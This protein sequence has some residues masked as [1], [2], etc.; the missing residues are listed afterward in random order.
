MHARQ[1]GS[2]GFFSEREEEERESE[3]KVLFLAGAY[4]HLSFQTVSKREVHRSQRRKHRFDLR[5]MRAVLP[6]AEALSKKHGYGLELLAHPGAVYEDK[7]LIRTT[8]K[9]DRLF[10]TSPARSREAEALVHICD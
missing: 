9:N 5:R 7:D 8:N 10:F 4:R 1:Y 2:A 6:D 3:Q